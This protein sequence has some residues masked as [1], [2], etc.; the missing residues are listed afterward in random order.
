M[1]RREVW[2]Q[3]G[4]EKVGEQNEMQDSAN[5]SSASLD[6]KKCEDRRRGSSG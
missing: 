2:V 4:S 1:T 3:C 6:L 5:G